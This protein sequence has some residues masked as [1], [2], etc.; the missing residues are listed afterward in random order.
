MSSAA[1][2]AS[3]RSTRSPATPTSARRSLP[4]SAGSPSIWMTLALG[5]KVSRLAGGAVVEARAD[6]DQEVA[7][8]DRVRWRRALPCMPDHAEEAGVGRKAP[9]PFSVATEG[10]PVRDAN[11][12]NAASPRPPCRRRRRNTGAASSPPRSGAS[13]RAS[14]PSSGARRPQPWACTKRAD[15]HRAAAT[16]LG[17]SI[18]T[19]PGRPEARNVE[20]LFTTRGDVVGIARSARNASRSAASAPECR[21]PGKRR[22]P[23]RPSPP[24]R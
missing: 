5:A 4:I 2:S 7:L 13:A 20:R 22:C 1:A 21:L 24:G 11:A 15:V 18:S 8:V 19:G 6:A 10:M 9:S 23:S 17:R 16:S 3:R 14:A 12:R